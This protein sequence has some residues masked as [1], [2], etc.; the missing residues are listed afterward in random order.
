[1][2]TDKEQL[3]LIYEKAALK[4][5]AMKKRRN[6]AGLVLSLALCVIILVAASF[7]APGRPV[8]SDILGWESSTGPGDNVIVG[9]GPEAE[10]DNGQLCT[11]DEKQE[12]S[13]ACG[14]VHDPVSSE[15]I[16]SEEEKSG[17]ETEETTVISNDATDSQPS[18]EPS[19]DE[20]TSEPPFLSEPEHSDCED[21]DE[22]KEESFVSAERSDEIPDS[23]EEDSEP[24]A[25]T[26]EGI[27]SVEG[28]PSSSATEYESKEEPESVTGGTDS[29]EEPEST[30]P[31][32]SSEE[33]GE[34]S[35]MG[36]SLNPGDI[37]M[38]PDTSS[39]TEESNDS[40]VES[41]PDALPLPLP[42][43]IYVLSSN[44]YCDDFYAQLRAAETSIPIF[45]HM[46]YREKLG[47][48]LAWQ[49]YR[50]VST[51]FYYFNTVLSFAEAETEDEMLSCFAE[52]DVLP[53]AY[54]YLE[55]GMCYAMLDSLSV[56][57]L[58]SA[59]VYCCSLGS[60]YDGEEVSTDTTE[61]IDAFCDMYGDLYV[62]DNSRVGNTATRCYY[63]GFD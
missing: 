54:A 52:L 51:G 8:L 35:E 60:G 27:E 28:D 21:S 30:Q 44:E 1:M 5:E 2:R 39:P 47:T 22:L 7:A 33:T 37:S 4:L 16:F 45:A 31:E 43:T 10:S 19:R 38:P 40:T 53:T 11:S 14:A 26:L 63:L 23:S 61:G 29:V 42:N 20:S 34:V 48:A 46:P 41:S 49:L 3:E 55:E 24:S 59:G 58:A 13:E 36:G 15:S 9:Q 57:K 56:V 50:S 6:R 18:S 25:E 12:S 62:M 32:E 17:A